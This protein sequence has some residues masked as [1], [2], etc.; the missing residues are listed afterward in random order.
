MSQATRAGGAGGGDELAMLAIIGA[1]VTAVATWAGA[2]AAALVHAGR[3]MPAS[4]ADGLRAL[5]RIPA[6]ASEPRVSWE[7]AV[8]ELLPG[9]VLYWTTTSV[10]VLVALGIVVGMYGR[11]GTTRVGTDRKDRLGVTPEARLARRR[12]LKPLIVK[13]PTA[14]RFVMGR[15]GRDLVAT[16]DRTTQSKQAQRKRE[17]TRVGDR[18]AVVVVGPSRCGK[19]ANVTAG[20]L[21]WDG[22]A[23][24]SSVKDDLYNATIGRRRQLGKVFVFDPFGELPDDLGDGV[25]RVGWSPLQASTSISGAQQ[26]AA[27]LLDAGPTE[28]VTNANYWSTKGQQLLWPMLFAAATNDRTMGDVVRW[29]ALQDGE[30]QSNSQIARLLSETASTREGAVGVEARQALTAFAGFWLLEPRTRSDIFSTA[31]TVITAW[32]DPYVAAA[33]ATRVPTQHDTIEQPAMNMAMLLEG[34]NTLYLVQPLKSAERFSVL[35]G[36]LLGDLLRDQAYDISKRAGGPIPATL[37]VIDEAGNTPLRWLPEVASTCSGIGIQLVTVWQS[38]A[39]MRAT[40]Q[41]QTESLL[42]NHG[43]KIFFSGL[44]DKETLDYASYVGGEEEVAQQSMT[45]DVGMRG[46]RRSV[47][48]S[49]TRMRFLPADLM[50]QVPPGSALL[51]HG[52]LPPAHLVGRRPWEER[53]LQELAEGEAPAPEAVERSNRFMNA[54]ATK[55]EVSEFVLALMSAT[56]APLMP[57][58]DNKSEASTDREVPAE[59]RSD[60]EPEVELAP[61]NK[62]AAPT[63]PKLMATQRILKRLNAS[64]CDSPSVTIDR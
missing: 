24:L 61:A 41:A 31:Q 35:F 15:V 19:T 38:L 46:D 8:A 27:T 63:D 50:R 53:R 49:T 5:V 22:P 30:K 4:P 2:Q 62:P 1:G 23:V 3:T 47:A 52:T 40:Y 42:T 45:T 16:E 59:D 44:S 34:E 60:S 36:G 20:V 9:P 21:E 6:N 54:L 29:L 55:Q 48:A 39:Q 17:R 58:A 28:G 57:V 26:A 12:D 43:S 14:G 11:F 18:S 25:C 64:L 51:L 37:A 13:R 10:V 7:P 32:E 33:S 56:P